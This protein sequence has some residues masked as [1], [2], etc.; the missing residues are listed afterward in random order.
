[1]AAPPLMLDVGDP[2]S[3]MVRGDQVP[4][5]CTGIVKER[6]GSRGAWDFLFSRS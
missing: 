4:D 2:P 1:M 6:D 3:I 5:T